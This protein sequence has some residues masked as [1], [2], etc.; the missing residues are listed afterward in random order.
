[1]AIPV[2]VSAYL[3]RNHVNHTVIEHTVAYKAQEEGAV[4]RQHCYG[5]RGDAS[6]EIPYDDYDWRKSRDAH[7]RPR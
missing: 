5:T 6:T 2:T 7:A 3:G 1:M 4:L